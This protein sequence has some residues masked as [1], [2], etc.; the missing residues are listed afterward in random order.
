MLDQSEKIVSGIC[1]VLVLATGAVYL[2]LGAPS[3]RS[4]QFVP[5]VKEITPQKALEPR[6]ADEPVPPEEKAI[7]DN[8]LAQGRK[9][10]PGQR[11]QKK[12]SQVPDKLFEEISTEANWLRE[13]NKAASDALSVNGRSTRRRL[14]QIEQD[15]FFDKLGFKDNDIVE[16][17]DGQILEFSDSSTAK[18]YG[19]WESALKKLRSGQSVSVTVTRN[20]QP[21]HLEFKL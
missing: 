11:L 10:L 5:A 3:T 20:N 15:S 8:L 18:Y 7:V 21:L 2:F 9:L 14:H 12:T 16:L 19:M 13:L 4:A 17:V 6:K 1:L